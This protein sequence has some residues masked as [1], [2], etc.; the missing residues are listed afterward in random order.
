MKCSSNA[1]TI[2]LL[3]G[4]IWNRNNSEATTAALRLLSLLEADRCTSPC[5]VDSVT[6]RQMVSVM[7]QAGSLAYIG[8]FGIRITPSSTVRLVPGDGCFAMSALMMD[9]G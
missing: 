1:M 7:A 4:G 8:S 5:D 6:I 3:A 9:S 2:D